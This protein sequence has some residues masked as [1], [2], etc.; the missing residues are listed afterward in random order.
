MP[1]AQVGSGDD[2]CGLRAALPPTKTIGPQQGA[3]STPA[4]ASIRLCEIRNLLARTLQEAVGLEGLVPHA[5][6]PPPAVAVIIGHGD[7]RR[8]R[9]MLA[10]TFDGASFDAEASPSSEKSLP[11]AP[12]VQNEL[13]ATFDR[14]TGRT[15]PAA[16]A[17]SSASAHQVADATA[18][19]TGIGERVHSLDGNETCRQLR[20]ARAENEQLRKELQR[21]DFLVGVLS[22]QFDSLLLQRSSGSSSSSRGS[23]L[24]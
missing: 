20:L 10:G 1:P 16:A 9:V 23:S 21:A 24:G 18:L 13:E 6:Q 22:K 17:R 4:T 8:T 12:R 11:R 3:V 2:R 5:G 15:A 7:G 14:L 19:R